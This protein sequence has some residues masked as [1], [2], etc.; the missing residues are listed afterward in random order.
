MCMRGASDRGPLDEVHP[1]YRGDNALP[2]YSGAVFRY[3][4]E[5][6]CTPEYSGTSFR[7]FDLSV[8]RWGVNGGIEEWFS[9]IVWSALL[10]GSITYASSAI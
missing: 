2:V 9:V 10:F 8:G 3:R 6:R 7:Y 1:C 5:F 4:L